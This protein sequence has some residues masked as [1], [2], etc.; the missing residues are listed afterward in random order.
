[1]YYVSRAEED[2]A[3]TVQ[4]VISA[5]MKRNGADMRDA[6]NTDAKETRTDFTKAVNSAVGRL[7]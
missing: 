6:V 3:K 2:K 4:E 5:L 1:M 7:Y